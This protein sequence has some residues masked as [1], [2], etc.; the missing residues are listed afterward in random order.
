MHPEWRDPEAALIATRQICRLARAHGA[1]VHVLHVSTAEE[2]QVLAD[3]KDVATVEVTPQHLT[4]SAPECYRDRGTHAQMN[5]PIRDARHR[6]GLWNGVAQRIVDVIGSDH[7][8]HQAAEKDKPYPTSPSGIPGVQTLLPLMLDHVAQGRLTLEHLAE[9]TS[10]GPARVFNVASKGR[11]AVGYD[12][13]LALVDLN[14]RTTITGDWLA[15]KAGFSPFEGREVT[16]W[17]V[18]TLLRGEIA[19]R[20]GELLGRPAGRPVR[21]LETLRGAAGAA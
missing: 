17:P 15:S 10:S 2:M 19:A 8:P 21:F 14:R 4:L 12:A 13:D 6:A 9:L 18:A 7:A 5:P 20:D 3:Y 16:G 11:I 1:R